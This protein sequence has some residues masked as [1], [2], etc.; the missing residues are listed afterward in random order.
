[1]WWADG[2]SYTQSNLVPGTSKPKDGQSMLLPS[3]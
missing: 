3:N 1:L 2:N